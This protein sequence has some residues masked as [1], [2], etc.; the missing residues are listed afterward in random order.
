M[1]KLVIGSVPRG[2]DYF[3]REALIETLWS[4]LATDSVL[5]VAPRRFGKTG[6]MYRLLD[7]PQ[8]PFRPIYIDV[9][10]ITPAANFMVELIAVLL[11][12]RHFARVVTS[13]WEETKD[14]GKYVR[15][16]PESIE[17]GTFKVELRERSDVPEHWLSYGDR[18]MSLLGRDEQALL[19]LLDEF[20][21]MIEQIM[22]RDQEE[23]RQFLRWFRGAR[24][25]PD[26]KTRF[27]IRGSINLV[28]TLDQ[29]GLVDTVNDLAIV[30]LRP[31]DRDTA[32]R[33]V[34][35]VFVA[36]GKAQ[37]PEVSRT[38]LDLVGEPIPFLLAVLLTA[39][40]DRARA[41]N[42]AISVEMVHA[43]F[44][45]DLLGGATAAVF[46]H[47]RSRI[48]QYYPGPEGNAALAILGLLSRTDAPISRE[49]LY[50]TFL[51]IC[52][53][54]GNQED[55]EAFKRLMEKLDNDFY[56]ISQNDS[57]A[58]FSRV[59]GLWWKTHYGFQGP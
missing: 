14:F 36:H 35:A 34:E 58:F 26:T 33:F 17:V 30:R 47:Y 46:Q 31:F 38:I 6:A 8:P 4:R 12:D 28:P 11:R 15:S 40:F 29:F 13:L 43:A 44:A 48:D 21:I 18:V 59:V 54:S 50:A 19:L 52:S 24:L 5:L 25:A 56:V 37:T 23:A 9:A 32:E 20:P 16:L 1:P 42:D 53:R 51:K 49:T 2:S 45:E 3:G 57:Y 22:R 27:V 41:G 7:E 55:L 10:H 39:I